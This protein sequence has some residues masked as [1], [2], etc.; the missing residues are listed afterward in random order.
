MD[1]EVLCRPAAVLFV[2][3]AVEEVLY[4]G[5]RTADLVTDDSPVLST[6]VMGDYISNK[7]KLL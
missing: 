1:Q 6:S 4:E 5:Y 7:V 2:E 3:S